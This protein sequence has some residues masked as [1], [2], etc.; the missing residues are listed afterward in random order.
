MF[1]PEKCIFEVKFYLAYQITYF[2]RHF[3]IIK[4]IYKI[5]NYL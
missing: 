3:E 4:I 2:H 5:I 1:E